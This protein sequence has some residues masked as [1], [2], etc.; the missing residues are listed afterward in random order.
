MVSKCSLRD[1]L[2]TFLGTCLSP[3]RK[4]HPKIPPGVTKSPMVKSP[5]LTKSSGVEKSPGVAKSP[6]LDGVNV[7]CQVKEGSSEYNL[8]KLIVGKNGTREHPK[9]LLEPS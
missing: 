3:D 5:D 2:G 4:W 7:P 6:V 1:L 8:Q 9:S